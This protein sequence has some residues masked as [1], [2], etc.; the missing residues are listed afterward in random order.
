MTQYV[1]GEGPKPCDLM[2]VGEGPGQEEERYG[3]PFVGKSGA[4]LWRYLWRSTGRTRSSVYATNL[5]KHRVP[6]NE[7]PTEMDIARDAAA[8]VNEEEDVNPEVIITLGRWSSRN[9]LGDVDMEAVHGIPHF[10]CGRVIMPIVHPAAGLHSTEFQGIIAWDF[11]QLGKLLNG[12]D[13]PWEAVDE[14][15]KPEYQEIC[16][17]E[18]PTTCLAAVDTE[19]SVLKPWCLS[20]CLVPGQAAVWRPGAQTPAPFPPFKRV[21]LH[22]ALHDIPV[23]R[24]MGVEGCEFED[25]MIMAYLLNVEPQGL[26]ALAKRHCGMEMQ[27]YMDLVREPN[28]IYA[29]DYLIKALGAACD[30]Q[31]SSESSESSAIATKSRK[32]TRA[33]GGKKS[34][35]TRPRAGKK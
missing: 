12:D 10:R 35:R 32:P 22:S 7:D 33:K 1:H 14:L 27:D 29:I 2:I 9:Y 34:V 8:L 31:S 23:L 4:E 26:K 15:P 6:G 3:R 17:P 24:A 19:G 13:L 16:A 5:V 11:G 18:H 20:E 30:R 21:V 25:T 28:R